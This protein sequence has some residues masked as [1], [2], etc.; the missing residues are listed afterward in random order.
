M[1]APAAAR[2]VCAHEPQPGTVCTSTG[3][4][5]DLRRPLDYPAEAVCGHCG[6][7]IR[8]EQRELANPGKRWQLKYPGN[9]A[10]PGRRG[11]QPAVPSAGRGV[12]RYAGHRP[13]PR[14]KAGAAGEQNSQLAGRRRRE[15]VRCAMIRA[16]G[17]TWLR[18]VD[19]GGDP[20]RGGTTAETPDL[21]D[22]EEIVRGR[23]RRTRNTAEASCSGSCRRPL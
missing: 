21:E 14:S 13:V 20:I 18:R 7:P 19:D 5:D 1:S 4:V 16:P 11:G 15:A 6:E 10:A 8:R 22:R 2:Q 9:A 17:V 12:R 23:G 3:L